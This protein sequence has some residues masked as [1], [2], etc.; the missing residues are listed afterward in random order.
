MSEFYCFK[1]DCDCYNDTDEAYE[2]GYDNAIDDVLE[3]LSEYNDILSIIPA[4]YLQ[5]II[6]VIEQMK[7]TV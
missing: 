2:Q 1:A 3:K 6:C 4:S 7:I 5:G